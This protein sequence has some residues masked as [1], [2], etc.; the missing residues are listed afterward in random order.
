MQEI[1]IQEIEIQQLCRKFFIR[2][3]SL[4]EKKRTTLKD[5]YGWGFE[6]LRTGLM[7]QLNASARL[8]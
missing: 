2:A 6:W 4:L 8:L 7:T 1:V 3:R 5:L